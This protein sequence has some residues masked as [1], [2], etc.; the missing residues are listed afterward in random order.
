VNLGYYSGYQGIRTQDIKILTPETAGAVLPAYEE[1]TEM[2]PPGYMR[3][4]IELGVVD[5]DAGGNPTVKQT[6]KRGTIR[7]ACDLRTVVC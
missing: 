3:F 4:N 2:E 5:V 7:E 1:E 6:W